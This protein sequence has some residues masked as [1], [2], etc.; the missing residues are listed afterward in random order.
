MPNP[1]R[2]ERMDEDGFFVSSRTFITNR[3]TCVAVK[4]SDI[5]IEVRSTKDPTK[6][7][8]MFSREEWEAFLA[9][10]KSGEFDV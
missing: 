5:G 1:T 7:T 10:A 8:L 6:N 4:I 2:E 9:G 3:R